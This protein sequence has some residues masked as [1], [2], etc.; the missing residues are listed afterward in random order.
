MPIMPQLSAFN[1]F[2]Y[3]FLIMIGIIFGNYFK[4]RTYI[5]IALI[6]LSICVYYLIYLITRP[7]N[8]EDALETVNHFIAIGRKMK[9]NK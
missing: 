9:L 1:F 7:P 6:N 8:E 3:L 4:K 2:S 5:I